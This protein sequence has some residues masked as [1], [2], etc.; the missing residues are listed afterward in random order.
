MIGNTIDYTACGVNDEL[1]D[2]EIGDN[3]TINEVVKEE[4]R[5]EDNNEAVRLIGEILSRKE[6]VFTGDNWV[7]EAVD[8]LL[9]DSD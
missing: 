8:F 7:E 5:D 9:V 1:E 4:F 2:D 3:N 6:G